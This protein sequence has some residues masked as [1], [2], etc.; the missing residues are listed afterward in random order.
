MWQGAQVR[1]IAIPFGNWDGVANVS[2]GTPRQEGSRQR[3]ARSRGG[4]TPRLGC[5]PGYTGKRCEQRTR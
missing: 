2:E 5:T 3:R 4:L 1:S